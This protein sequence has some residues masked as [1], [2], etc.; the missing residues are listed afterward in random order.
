M[1]TQTW[2]VSQWL[3]QSVFPFTAQPLEHLHSIFHFGGVKTDVP[4]K[5]KIKHTTY[6]TYRVT[7]PKPLQNMC[8]FLFTRIW[9]ARGRRENG[10]THSEICWRT[11]LRSCLSRFWSK[12]SSA[13]APESLPCCSSF[14]FSSS[15]SSSASKMAA[16]LEPTIFDAAFRFSEKGQW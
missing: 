9:D 1:I 3:Q 4:L 8:G 11:L 16:N 7:F 2:C 10:S 13:L 14:T 15:S 6:F 12:R 5:K